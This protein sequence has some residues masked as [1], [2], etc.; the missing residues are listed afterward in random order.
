[1]LRAGR[2]S[3]GLTLR[4]RAGH[5]VRAEVRASPLI[6]AEGKPCLLIS[7]AETRLID[8]LERDIAVVDALVDS[9]PLGIA[10]YG[11]DLR[12]V[13]VNEELTRVVGKS[14]ED[15]LGRTVDQVNP[16]EVGRTVA[17]VQ[18]GVL[19]TGVPVVDF[20]TPS[21]DGKR[22]RSSS[23]SRIADN[24][25]R[26]LGLTSIVME[27]TERMAA[28]A[29]T[30]RAR[31]RL[32]LLNDI[33][34]ALADLL[35]V[36]RLAQALA[37]G[38]VPAFADYACVLLVQ[39]VCEGRE[40]SGSPY[41]GDT[42]LILQGAA[43]RPD[44]AQ[45]PLFLP[46]GRR[47]E[48]PEDTPPAEV[49]AGRRAAWH[50][51]SPAELGSAAAPG[52]HLDPRLRTALELGVGSAIVVPLRA[53]GVVLGL[54][55]VGRS[56]EREPFDEEDLALAGELA[57]RAAIALDNAR[58]YI[59]V[60]EDALTLQRG[61]LPQ[62]VPRLPG[63]ETAHRYVP[64]SAGAEAGGDWFDVVPLAGGRVAFVIGDVMGHGLRAA[65]T[66]GRVRTAVRTLAT[67]DLAPDELLH[68]LNVL[69]DDFALSAED[70]MMATLVYA[71]YDP[72]TRICAMARAGHLSP[73]MCYDER[74]PHGEPIC[75]VTRIHS[76]PGLPI[77]VDTGVPEP[78]H[79][80]TVDMLVPAGAVLVL[81][82]DGLVEARGADIGEGQE[83]LCTVLGEPHA[84]LE[85]ACDDVLSTMLPATESDDVALLVAR[86]GELPE[87]SSVSWTFP[88]EPGVVRQGRVQ[89]RDTLTAWGL[90][91]LVDVTALLVTELVTNSLRHSRGPIGVR[92]VRG[93]SLL[94]EVSDPT[95]DPPRARMAAF[96]EEGGRG[97]HLVARVAKR[98]GTRLGPLGKTVWF[99]LA[100]PGA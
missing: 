19:E 63:I 10:I 52:R 90:A 27:V 25:G 20:R 67:L 34:R 53:R 7:L 46:A 48:F 69:S 11:T 36:D 83:R 23:F 24:R 22:V 85:E 6:D 4:H 12:V 84:S 15:I 49:L 96:D 14:A 91:P 41:P 55:A 40:L 5:T 51:A 3:G 2:W 31:A 77:G 99:E 38:L 75:R 16:G 57:D 18:R 43:C 26:V 9:S 54:L 94:V 32:S 29:R 95:P 44:D 47:L 64:G 56:T 37:D 42:T 50:A 93:T 30:E 35:D 87:G 1:V 65:A 8:Q 13:R 21:P 86:L 97:L 17:A 88:A 82:T 61:L 76:P 45:V 68:R 98:W 62:R 60:R 71:V 59:R 28:A 39:A 66:M 70:P 80:E 58:L 74:G 33:D 73:L 78:V 100:L 81:F 92:M 72:S 89:V 79:F